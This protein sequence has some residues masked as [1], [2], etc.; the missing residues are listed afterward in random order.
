MKHFKH[1]TDDVTIVLTRG[2]FE[3]LTWALGEA[4]SANNNG[5]IDLTAENKKRLYTVA[6]LIDDLE[7][8]EAL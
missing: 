4:Y 6:D 8:G 2:E 3:A 7:M 5:E 1:R